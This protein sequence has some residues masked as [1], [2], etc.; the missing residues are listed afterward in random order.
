VLIALRLATAVGKFAFTAAAL[1]LLGALAWQA[2]F[3][4]VVWLIAA[5]VLTLAFTAIYWLRRAR[6]L[7]AAILAANEA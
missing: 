5:I 3:Y 6:R 7:R 4:W 1:L 2:K